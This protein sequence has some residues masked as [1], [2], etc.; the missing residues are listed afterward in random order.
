MAAYH[1]VSSFLLICPHKFEGIPEAIQYIIKD[2]YMFKFDLSSEYHHVSIQKD[3]QKYLGFSWKFK[4]TAKYGGKNPISTFV[5][6]SQIGCD[7]TWSQPGFSL[8]KEKVFGNLP[9]GIHGSVLSGI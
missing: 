8:T 7:K 6:L 5:K 1:H 9:G 4:N 3:H 2:G